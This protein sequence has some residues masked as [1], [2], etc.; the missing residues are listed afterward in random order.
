MVSIFNLFF[1]F[2]LK[3]IIIISIKSFEWTQWHIYHYHNSDYYHYEWF[4]FSEKLQINIINVIYLGMKWWFFSQ[5][6][7]LINQKHTQFIS[8]AAIKIKAKLY[9][10]ASFFFHF[11]NV[12][13]YF[14]NHKISNVNI[15][16]SYA[17]GGFHL[18]LLFILT[19]NKN[20]TLF[21]IWGCLFH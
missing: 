4:D 20:R 3:L 1:L 10:L 19:S 15:Q 17:H 9:A 14:C 18:F 5:I 11:M 7:I 16:I 8:K 12:E 21:L 13:L 2:I 6:L